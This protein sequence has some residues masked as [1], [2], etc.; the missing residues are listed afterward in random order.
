VSPALAGA[1]AP[2]I[3]T[4]SKSLSRLK[5]KASIAEKETLAPPPKRKRSDAGGGGATIDPVRKYCLGKLEDVF[6]EVFL[7]YPYTR[8]VAG[9]SGET[10]DVKSEGQAQ[11]PNSQIV[12][13]KLEELTEEEKESLIEDSRNFAAEL[14]RCVFDNYSEGDIA[15]AKYKYVI[16]SFIRLFLQ[17]HLT[18]IGSERFNS[19]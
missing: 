18:G 19:T 6:K 10:R 11:I 3:S 8:S 13:K 7:R 2:V 16:S 1:T 4:S 12:M 17:L 9:Q 14:E 5:R 15:G